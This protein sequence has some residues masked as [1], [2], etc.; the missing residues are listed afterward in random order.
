[1]SELASMNNSWQVAPVMPDSLSC[2]TGNCMFGYRQ[3]RD[4]DSLETGS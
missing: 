4:E 2:D 1:V 3:I